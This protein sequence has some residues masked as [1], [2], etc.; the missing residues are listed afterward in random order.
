ALEELARGNFEAARVHASS[1][2]HRAVLAWTDALLGRERDC[3]E[4]AQEA[5][6]LASIHELEVPWHLATLALGELELGLGRPAHALAQ[7]TEVWETAASP[8]FRL[9]VAPNLVE[10][11]VRADRRTLATEVTAAYAELDPD[12]ALLTRCRALVDGS[13]SLFEEAIALHLRA[14]SRF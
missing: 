6:R 3:R 13:E 14:G 9:L 4:H 11:A 10:A 8:A 12:P 1:G 5:F 2:D 7:L